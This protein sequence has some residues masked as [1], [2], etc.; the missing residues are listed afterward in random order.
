[1]LPIPLLTPEIPKVSARAD[2]V[3]AG[4]LDAFPAAT[5]ICLDEGKA[6]ARDASDATLGAAAEAILD[7]PFGWVVVALA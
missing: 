7:V 1:M 5:L 4:R 2:K 6:A 3:A